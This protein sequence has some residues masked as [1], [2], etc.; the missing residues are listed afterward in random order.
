MA[1]TPEQP[2]SQAGEGGKARKFKFPTAFTVLFAVLLLVWIA[3]FFVPAGTYKT[4]AKTGAPVPGTYHKLPSCD[5]PAT[6]APAIDAD[7][8]TESGVAPT[9]AESAPGATITA[10]EAGQPCVDTSFMFRFKQL[11]D[12]PPNGLYGVESANGFVGPWE[13]GFLYGSA[14]IFF[15]VLAVGAFITVTMKT[16]AIQ[17]GIG[18]LALRFRSSGS[19]L[20]AILMAVFALGGTS[21]GMW[22]ET[23]GFFVLLVPLALALGYDRMT[24]AAI[25]FLGAGSGVIASTVNPFST[26]VASDAAGISIGDGI[27]L[28][29]AMWFVLVSLAIAYVIWYTRRIQAHPE[30]SVVG[31]SSSD[32]ADAQTLIT[33]VPALTGRQKI[34]L[35]L[36]AGTFLV[37]I[38]GFIPWNDLW[39]E[40]FGNNFPLPTFA[41]F[42]FPEAATLFLVMAVVIGLIAKLGEEGTVTTIV[43]G[44][45]DFLGA[46]LIIVVARGIT[47]VMKNAYMTD[48]VLHWME[49]AVSG[50]SQGTFGL[51]AFVVNLPIAFL[52]PSSSGH[53]A[54]VMP[55]L[56]PLADFAGVSRAVAVTAFQSASGLVNL[57]TPTS[58]VIMGGLALS[59]VGYNQY[60]KFVWPFALAVLVICGAFIGIAAAVG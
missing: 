27:G 31:I 47:V 13:E 17:T 50:K 32:A 60:I 30:R 21:Y 12:A 4:D 11:W 39:N 54:L 48:T 7:S 16:E 15:F 37:M 40:G 51:I 55:I 6:T 3:S 36:F 14:A 53:A 35:V 18:R 20:I 45:A 28:R 26:G 23:L 29:I 42:Y 10:G 46:G 44:A 1:E 52:V 43:A 24:A 8:P 56:A 5:A 57:V 49:N 2:S 25:I 9:D 58:A 33:D 41:D 38:Y 19:V 34:I 22:E 59:K